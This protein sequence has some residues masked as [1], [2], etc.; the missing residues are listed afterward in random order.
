MP[1]RLPS[2]DP[3]STPVAAATSAT[4]FTLAVWAKP[5]ADTTLHKEANEGANALS[6]A[7]QRRDLSA[8]RQHVWSGDACRQRPGHRAQRP[9]RVGARRRVLRC[10]C[11]CTPFRSEDWTHIAVVYRD[12]QPSLYL[13]GEL[14]DTGLKSTYTVHPGTATGDAGGSFVGEIGR[15][16]SGSPRA[17][18]RGGQDAH[19]VHAAS[20]RS[21]AGQ[22]SGTVAKSRRARRVPGVAGGRVCAGS[23]PM[24]TQRAVRVDAIPASL[25]IT[26]PWEVQFDPHWGGPQRVDFEALGDWTQ[27]P[28]EG[29]RHYSGTATYR[30]TI[31]LPAARKGQ[32]LWLDLGQVCDL[33]VVRL[34]GQSLGTLWLAPWRVEIT[35]AA[36]PGDNVLEVDV[37]NPWHNRLI[38]DL[39]LPP[40]QRRTYLALPVLTPNSPLLPAGLRGPVRIESAIEVEVE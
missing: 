35:H 21:S 11:W 40:D 39:S 34:N 5:A 20:R 27:H 10:R 32:R 13:N 7:A 22:R 9:V 18:S 6:A 17:G 26:G 15:S 3:A 38:G 19:A 14:V 25:H 28:E 8:A 29:I 16:G 1:R 12:A 4:A 37:I 23:V 24:G 30:K 33:A 2:R 31:S 36:R